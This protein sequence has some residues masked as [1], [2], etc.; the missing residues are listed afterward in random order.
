MCFLDKW[1]R[2][3]V[4]I[5]GVSFFLAGIT[6]AQQEEQPP[7][8]SSASDILAKMKQELNLNDEQLSRIT[9]IIQDDVQQMQ[10][11]MEQSRS[12][13]AGRDAVKNQMDVLRQNTESKLSQYLTQDQLIQ[14]EDQQ[15]PKEWD[16]TLGIEGFVFPNYEGS[17][18]YS[19]FLL[20]L[21]NINWRDRLSLGSRGVNLNLLCES[22]YKAGVGLTYDV[23]RKENG[24][25]PFNKHKDDS[26]NGRNDD[27]LNG[28]GNINSAVGICAF[29]SYN[30]ES[31]TIR[32]SIIRY[33][34]SQND[35]LL[36][37]AA[38]SKPYKIT[39]E[40]TVSPEIETTWA[41]R[42]YMEIYYGVSSKQAL[43]SQFS[44]YEAG[45]G[46]KD[47]GIGVNASYNFDYNW[48]LFANV[49]IKYLT[50]DAADSP[51]SETNT[52]CIFGA[53]IGYHF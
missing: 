10:M 35:G 6:F 45:A 20:P 15:Q 19:V 21:V 16:V 14:W 38:L 7:S 4:I 2:L 8:P 29:T 50:C 17:T 47:V 43:R 42:K 37:T 53:G 33:F 41:N 46:F 31:I 3:Y 23:G 44:Y 22:N 30:L 26:K 28:L 39:E 9:P 36:A 18:H 40:L 27:R 11:I 13:R 32:G 25:T 1:V 34:D 12:Q 24:S 48:V 51:I 49:R 52:N 5:F